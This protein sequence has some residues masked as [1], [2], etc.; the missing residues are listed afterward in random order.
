[1][2]K[3]EKESNIKKSDIDFTKE[4]NMGTK[5]IANLSNRKRE[6]ILELLNSVQKIQ[7]SS[8]SKTEKAAEIKKLM[9]INQTPLSKI[10]I[11]AFIGTIAG[12]FIF[13]SGGI[14]IAGLGGAIGIWGG[15][16]GTVGGVLISSLIQNF[17]KKSN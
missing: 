16:A 13:G 17:E 4:L 3:R 10:L 5:F 15:L 2:I 14:G 8:L 9:W 7:K 12:V 11:G 6:K 1:M